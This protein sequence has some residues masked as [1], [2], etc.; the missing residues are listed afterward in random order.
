MPD[1][2]PLMVDCVLSHSPPSAATDASPAPEGYEHLLLLASQLQECL[3]HTSHPTPPDPL[4]FPNPAPHTPSACP[5]LSCCPECRRNS[6]LKEQLK[7][8][9]GLSSSNTHST[10][11]GLVGLSRDTEATVS[12]HQ[13]VNPHLALDLAPSYD[14]ET[15][16]SQ[17]ADVVSREVWESPAGGSDGAD[18]S[19]E[20]WRTRSAEGASYNCVKGCGG[21]S[22]RDEGT[23]GAVYREE[24][25]RCCGGAGSSSEGSSGRVSGEGVGGGSYE[26]GGGCGSGSTST[27]NGQGAS[28]SSEA[29]DAF[30]DQLLFDGVISTPH[31]LHHSHTPHHLTTM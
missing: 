4:L 31:T 5:S 2:C 17:A 10:V 29:A 9:E 23:S 24:C 8:Q 26:V 1:V 22:Y 11:G 19:S 25:A 27:D 12:Q 6:V 7:S 28:Y 15:F 30:I 21:G 3:N 18:I 16:W 14:D 20:G 13:P